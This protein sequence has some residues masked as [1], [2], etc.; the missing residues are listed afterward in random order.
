MR[1]PLYPLTFH[2]LFKERVWGGR[3]IGTLFGKALPREKQIGESWEISDRPGDVSV[4]D[5]GSL[6]GRSLCQLIEERGS[7]I[8]GSARL[9][10][11][12]FPLL[13]KILDAQERLSLQ[14]HPPA[15]VAEVLK[16]EPKTEMWFVADCRPGADI[17]VGL[18]TNVTRS[19]FEEKMR[20]GLVAECFHRI[21]VKR[22][23]SMFL[24]SG[25]LHAIGAGNVIFEIQQNSD[26]TYRVFDWNRVGLDGQPRELHVESSLQSID[27]EDHEPSL[28]EGSLVEIDDGV[29]SRTM[30]ICDLFRVDHRRIRGEAAIRWESGEAVRVLGVV[31]GALRCEGNGSVLFLRAG[32]FVLLPAVVEIGV[33]SESDESEFLVATAQ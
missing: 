22:G 6:A 14:V 29:F 12:R 24:P 30:A 20:S 15:R 10:H 4:V 21:P 28:V 18:K 25:R 8:M 33:W 5:R 16:G 3:N 7:E 27:F 31:S 17:Y 19:S 2:P 13:V 11:G 1:E 32:S 23:D 9:C 26:T